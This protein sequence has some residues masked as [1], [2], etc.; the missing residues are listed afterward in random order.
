MTHA[1]FDL[2]FHAQPNLAPATR[3]AL[4]RRAQADARD[5]EAATRAAG[6]RLLGVSLAALSAPAQEPLIAADAAE[7]AAAEEALAPV[8]QLVADMAAND[9]SRDVRDLAQ[10]LARTALA[11][12]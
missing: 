5:P 3:T 7:K 1:A 2:A 11:A 12:A 9:P 4:L 10:K 8:L 6:L